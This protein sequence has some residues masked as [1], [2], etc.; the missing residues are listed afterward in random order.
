MGLLDD[1]KKQTADQRAREEAEQD[2]KAQR[3][4][5]YREQIKPKLEQICSFLHEFS[6]HLNYIKPDTRVNYELPGKVVLDDLLQGNYSLKS[7]SRDTMTE[8]VLKFYC[9]A[10]GSLFIDTVEKD[11]FD[12]LKEF[13]Y[14]NRIPYQTRNHKD[15]K[16]N[17]IGGEISVEKKVPV[18]FKFSADIDNSCIALWIRNFGSLGTRKFI[19]FPGQISEQ[20]L[21]SLGCYVMHETDSFIKLEMQDD[22]RLRIREKLEDEKQNLEQEIII[23]ERVRL[24]EE[25]QESQRKLLFRLKE[26]V[27]GIYGKVRKD[28]P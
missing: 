14:Q 12:R 17:V 13:L 15:S 27:R 11:R 6:E 16:Q 3:E 18:V 21:D 8:I 10:E 1:L 2:E 26:Q 20:F 19:L 24:E 25:Q 4:S 7:D 22:Q 9:Q 5:V 23:A 28:A